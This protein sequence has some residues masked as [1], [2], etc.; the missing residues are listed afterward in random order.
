[1]NTLETDVEIAAD[2]SM[3][4]LSPLPDWLKPGRAHV[5]LTVPDAPESKPQRQ[6]PQATPEMIARRMAAL[7]KVRVLDPTDAGEQTEDGEGARKVTQEAL[8]QVRRRAGLE[9]R[10]LPPEEQERRKQAARR[11]LSELR[12]SNPYLELAD[13][14]AWQRELRQDRPLPFRN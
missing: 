8:D 6:I 10:Q 14:V 13:P 3:R 11:A 12:E 4:L 2:G 9:R 7:E 1:M 5:L